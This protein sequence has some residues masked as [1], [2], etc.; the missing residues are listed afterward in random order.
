MNKKFKNT[1]LWT[2]VINILNGEEVVE[3]FYEK[4]C[5]KQIKRNLELKK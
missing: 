3:T 4:N 1:V 5:K 2:Y